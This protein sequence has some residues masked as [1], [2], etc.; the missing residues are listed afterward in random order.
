MCLDSHE[1]ELRKRAVSSQVIQTALRIAAVV[2]AASRI[3]AAEEA[4]AAG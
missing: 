3:V 1:E 4:R 2:N